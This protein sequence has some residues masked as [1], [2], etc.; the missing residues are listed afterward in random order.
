MAVGDC[1]LKKQPNTH[2]DEQTGEA[3]NL[4]K[5]KAAIQLTPIGRI[6]VQAC[7]KAHKLDKIYYIK[8]NCQ[9]KKN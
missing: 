9:R 4:H 8:R 6:G 7:Q 5:A 1:S 3:S 2:D